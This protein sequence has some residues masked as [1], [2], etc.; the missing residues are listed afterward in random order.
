MDPEMNDQPDP[1]PEPPTASPSSGGAAE[2]SAAPSAATAGGTAPADAVSA[3][4]LDADGERPARPAG[5][6][7]GLVLAL[8]GVVMLLASQQPFAETT[9]EGFDETGLVDWF[10]DPITNIG[11][12]DVGDFWIG[13]IQAGWLLWGLTVVFLAAGLGVAFS[14]SRR[15][16]VAGA[17]IAAVAAIAGAVGLLV[18][19]AHVRDQQVKVANAFNER[20]ATTDLGV[21]VDADLDTTFGRGLQAALLGLAVALGASIWILVVARKR[22]A[23]G[24]TP[25]AASPSASSQAA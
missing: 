6:V 16:A 9:G 7:A 14:S 15:A 1:E 5:F 13:G 24:S 21:F 11:G 20:L 17:V 4:E 19:L 18:E 2:A 8:A 23:A 25:D 22:P 10:D 12:I 3:P